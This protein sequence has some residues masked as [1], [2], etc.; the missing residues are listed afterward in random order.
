MHRPKST[1]QYPGGRT[2]TFSQAIACDGKVCSPTDFPLRKASRNL[3]GG[4]GVQNSLGAPS[5][6]AR[7]LSNRIGNCQVESSTSHT[8]PNDCH[9]LMETSRSRL[10]LGIKLIDH[11][12]ANQPASLR[13]RRCE[14]RKIQTS[15]SF[16]MRWMPSRC[17]SFPRC[18]HGHACACC[19]AR[20]PGH[21][22]ITESGKNFGQ[23]F[24]AQPTPWW[25]VS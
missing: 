23:A 17:L 25:F 18:W 22:A 16:R 4:S 6:R 7:S 3:S 8:Y 14:K 2:V 21:G 5:W 15:I 9:Q 20:V 11:D 13:R 12:P 24:L 10:G 19:S 1:F